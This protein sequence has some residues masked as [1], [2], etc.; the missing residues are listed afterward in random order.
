MP[1]HDFVKFFFL[2]NAL[3]FFDLGP[4]FERIKNRA[5]QLLF[6]DGL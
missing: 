4:R 6:Y 5:F 2:L 3:N 1:E